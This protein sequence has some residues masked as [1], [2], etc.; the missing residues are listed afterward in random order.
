M[1]GWKATLLLPQTGQ[2]WLAKRL[3]SWHF[4]VI[5]RHYLA[6]TTFSVGLRPRM[7]WTYFKLLEHLKNYKCIAC[8]QA[9][10]SMS[11]REQKATWITISLSAS[12][13]SCEM[14]RAALVFINLNQK[15]N[16][17]SYPLF[18]PF[19]FSYI[20]CVP[21]SLGCVKTPWIVIW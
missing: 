5:C 20:L 18:P 9:I 14:H 21:Q 11:D 10:I 16:S 4:K 13:T 8:G 7:S 2:E 15:L 3:R 17:S 1:F 12:P 19:L 6:V